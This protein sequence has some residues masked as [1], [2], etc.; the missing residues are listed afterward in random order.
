MP[1]RETH[2]Y[3]AMFNAVSQ[4]FENM[5]FVE[6]IE[7]PENN[8]KKINGPVPWVSMLIHDPF[9]GE[10]RLAITTSLL[11]ELTANMFGLEADEITQ[12]Q[13]EDIIAE[14]L[15]TLTGLFMTALLPDDQTYQLGLPEHGTGDFPP[16]DEDSIAWNLEIDGQP[17]VII[18][19]GAGLLK[20]NQ[21]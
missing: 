13:Q 11:R 8:R 15:N 20:A 5:A 9:Q 14:I 12:S 6:V 4:T 19:S 1:Y 2:L 10:I 18:G 16:V 7:Q 17:L 21:A 3:Q